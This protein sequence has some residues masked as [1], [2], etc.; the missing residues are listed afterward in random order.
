MTRRYQLQRL[1]K[2]ILLGF[3]GV[4]LASTMLLT[5]AQTPAGVVNKNV[6]K[7]AVIQMKTLNKAERVTTK[8]IK[9]E[10]DKELDE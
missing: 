8:I 9:K 1:Q 2:N 10:L 7:E 4:T 5:G 6:E 3:S